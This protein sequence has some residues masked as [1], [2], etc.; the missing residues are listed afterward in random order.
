MRA[1]KTL[2]SVAALVGMGL[3]TSMAMGQVL[4]AVTGG[5]SQFG[6]KVFLSSVL[7]QRGAQQHTHTWNDLV[8]TNM[9][10]IAMPSGGLRTVLLYADP[11]DSDRDK[12]MVDQFVNTGIASLG[13]GPGSFVH[14][15][16]Y[17]KL[18]FEG[19]VKN[20]PG[21][22]VLV[23]AIG[24]SF[25]SGGQSSPTSYFISTD[26]L[27]AWLVGSGTVS[28]YRLPTVDSIPYY[29]IN[30]GADE[31]NDLLGPTTPTGG[32]G[33]ST[34]IAQ[35]VIQSLDL[36]D[37]GVAAGA[38]V[39]E[40]WMQDS[41]LHGNSLHPT[42]VVGLP[43]LSPI[44]AADIDNDGDVDGTDL[45]ILLTTFAGCEGDAGYNP[46]ADINGDDC[47]DSTDLS[48][49]LMEFGSGL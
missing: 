11:L 25:T 21:P 26:G 30:G 20:E 31:P 23:V 12:T 37:Y 8:Q 44:F 42:M 4:A 9:T 48:L 40:F 49:L 6:D 22:D 35:P 16:E 33:N 34:A 32:L 39:T 27:G 43:P 10:E 45:S 15:T 36:S 24:F 29:A 41:S 19:P 17:I 14:G 1:T 3:A 2:R 7:V 38:I 18:E 13:S 46:A 47:V 28:E 5:G